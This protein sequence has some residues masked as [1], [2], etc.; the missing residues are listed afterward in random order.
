[1]DGELYP[2]VKGSSSV[3]TRPMAGWLMVYA[4]LADGGQMVPVVDRDGHYA[5]AAKELGRVDWT[6]YRKG[7]KWNDSHLKAPKG[8]PD[9]KWI[10][11]LSDGLEFHDGSTALSAAHRKVGFWTQGHLFDATDPRSWLGLTDREGRPRSPTSEEFER[12]DRMWQTAVMLKGTPRPLGLSADGMMAL[13]SATR[14]RIQYAMVAQAAVCQLPKN[15]A[16]TLEPMIKGVSPSETP[17]PLVAMTKAMDAGAAADAVPE[18][19]E[20]AGKGA[21]KDASEGN[22][23]V[24]INEAAKQVIEHLMKRYR[25]GESDAK[26]L[27][28]NYVARQQ[29]RQEA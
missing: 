9:D 15:H 24:P 28:T 22:D 25:I 10:I 7:R 29:A 27:L 20:G 18:D 1:M 16:A 14:T 5:D 23:K 19:L 3:F 13:D 21:K 2:L 26:A 17:D 4:M 11:G 6:E 8:H 12:A